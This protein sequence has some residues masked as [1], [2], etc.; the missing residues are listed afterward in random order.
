VNQALFPE[1][2]FIMPLK[3]PHGDR[4]NNQSDSDTSIAQRPSKRKARQRKPKPPA[5]P[6]QKATV[7]ELA[8]EVDPAN[9]PFTTNPP[10]EARILARIRKCFAIANHAGTPE[11]EAKAAL[12]M[13]SKLMSQYNVTQ[14]EAFEQSNDEDQAQHGGRSVV[15]I[16]AIHRRA[17]NYAFTDTLACAMNVFFDCKNYST[18]LLSSIEWTFYGIADNTAAAAMAFEM[19]YN[20]ILDWSMPKKGTSPNNSY[21]RGFADGLYRIAQEEKRE[22]M[23]KAREKEEAN[24]AKRLEEEQSERQKEIDRLN[25]QV[26][27]H[28]F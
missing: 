14:A 24:M 25:F 26:S 20:L 22:E 12:R 16:T 5:R 9:H 10:A 28:S 11:T 1:V 21:S 19:T 23:K 17:V 4:N 27:M 3:R 6:K 7:K 15:A 2:R 18:G 8:T 13:G